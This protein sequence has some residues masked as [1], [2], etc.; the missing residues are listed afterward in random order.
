MAYRNYNP[1]NGFI[2]SQTVGEGDFT[3]ISSALAVA[4]AGKTIFIKDGIYNENPSLKA[5]VNLTAWLGDSEES[6]VII[7]GKCTFSSAGTVNIS[8][9]RLQTNSDYL[10]EV[11]G[12]AASIVNI[13]ECYLNITNN[14]G[15]H[16]TSSSGSSQI[17]VFDSDGNITTTGITLCTLAGAGNLQFFNSTVANTG[18]ATTASTISSGGFV[19]SNSLFFMPITTSST[20]GFASQYSEWNTTA[21]NTT[22]LTIGGSGLS[23]NYFDRIQSGTASAVSISSTLAMNACVIDSTNTHIITGAGTLNYSALVFPQGDTGDINVSTQNPVAWSIQQGGTAASSFNIN[24]PVISNTTTTGALSSITLTNQ[25]FLVGNTS[26]APTAKAFSVVNQVFTSTGTY[27]PTSGMVYCQIIAIG[28]GGAGGGAAI[29][30]ATH[31][32]VGGGGGAGEYA[33]GIFSAATIG[34]SQ[35]VTIGAAGTGSAG[36]TGGSGGN[37]SV[38]STLISANGGVGGTTGSGTAAAP[39]VGGGGLGGGSGLNGDYRTSGANGVWGVELAVLNYVISGQGAN[40]VLGAG[41]SPVALTSAAGNAGAGYGAGGGGG[42]NQASQA[43]A[44]AGGN[45]TKGV[46]IIQEY[47]LS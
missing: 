38:G 21:I 34:A 43:A 17:N 5:G 3:S 32:S 12:S 19:S 28:G 30:D 7:N 16:L 44:V 18:N 2:V 1:A 42:A 37:T 45:G 39:A 13:E 40:S 9:V 41:G 29:T 14:T 25:K 11:T 36:A 8:N 33:V 23:S 24:G 4:T 22:A 10:L 35:S 26:A 6:N 27:T 20:A 31:N 15:I 46:V 47:I